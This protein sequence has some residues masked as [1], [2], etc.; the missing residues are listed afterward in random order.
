MQLENWPISAIVYETR[1]NIL[2]GKMYTATLLMNRDHRCAG[3]FHIYAEGAIY[4]HQAGIQDFHMCGGLQ[5]SVW[6][7]DEAGDPPLK[8]Y[9]CFIRFAEA[10]RNA[11]RT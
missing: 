9:L 3:Q 4:R 5:G 7:S 2:N 8:C 10:V 11:V 6:S 1:V